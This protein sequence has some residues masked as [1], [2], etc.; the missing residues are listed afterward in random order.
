MRP[1]VVLGGA[2]LLGRAVTRRAKASGRDDVVCL[3]KTDCNIAV[4]DSVGRMFDKYRPRAVIVAAA[5]TNVDHCSDAGFVNAVAPGVI[6]KFAPTWLVSTNYVFDGKGPHHPKDERS[7]VGPYGR[8][9]AQAE[10]LVLRKGG[11]VVRT[12]W[13]FG[14][15]GGNFGSSLRGS[16]DRMAASEM[17]AHIKAADDWPVQPTFVDDLADYLLGLPKGVTHAIGQDETTWYEFAKAVAGPDRA[18]FVCPCKL[19]DIPMNA[20]RPDDGRLAPAILPGWRDGLR[21]WDDMI[22]S[23]REP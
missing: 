20:P 8:Q 16:L 12:G 21:R 10:D 6:A 3:S 5:I 13:L 22:A 15:G 23:E 14:P 17:K 2:G 9:K 4:G 7:P 1:V 19:A 18:K 11:H